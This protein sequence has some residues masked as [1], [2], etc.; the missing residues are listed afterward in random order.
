MADATDKKTKKYTRGD[1]AEGILGATLTAKFV[2]RPKS[3]KDG[4]VKVTKQMVDKVLDDFY[5]KAKLI[6]YQANDVVA[7]R[8]KAT[9]DNVNFSINLPE[10]AADFLRVKKNR[11]IVDD[12]YDSA[13]AYVEK[14]WSDEVM[15]FALNGQMDTIDIISDGVGD[16]KGTKA[17][18]KITVNG[19]PHSRQ[20]S[21]KVAGGEQF[22]QVSGSDF[23]KQMNLWE[24]IL[25]LDISSLEKKYNK[26]LEKYDK[27]LIFSSREDTKLKAFKD[28]LK[29]AAAVVYKDA[30]AQMQKK[31]TSKDAKFYTNLANLVFMGAT[32]GDQSIELVKL[33]QR[34]FKQLQFNKDFL[35]LYSNQLKKSNLIVKFSTTGDPIV[36][37]YAGSEKK[38]NLLLQIRTKIEAQSKMT[39]SGKMYTPYMRNYIEAGPLMFNL[40]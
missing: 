34:K 4:N 8:G 11:P 24:D 33:E 13:I 2:N 5:K 6:S 21:L 29:N 9:I 28:M 15:I 40:L 38:D 23:S 10:A 19:K 31:I 32:K 35:R 36:K 22:S 16:Q 14:T 37:V 25:K 3:L 12:L 20:I 26:A 30:A 27:K 18:I 7:K 17:D 1:I 39:K